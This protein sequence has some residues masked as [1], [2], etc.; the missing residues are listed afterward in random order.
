M[1]TNMKKI[2]VAVLGATGMVGQRMLQR[3]SVHPFFEI[4]YLGASS[5]SA[6]KRYKDATQWRLEGRCPK[7]SKISP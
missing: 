2:K 6:G 3:L 1:S 5:R 4:A 7:T